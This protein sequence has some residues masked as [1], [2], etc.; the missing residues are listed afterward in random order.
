MIHAFV[1]QKLTHEVPLPVSEDVQSSP[2][3]R[4]L[5]LSSH[6]GIKDLLGYRVTLQKGQKLSLNN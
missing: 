2:S 1:R 3:I 6:Q 4:S 5:K